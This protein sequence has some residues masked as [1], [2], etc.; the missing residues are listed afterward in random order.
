M[1]LH[2]QTA[3]LANEFLPD[4]ESD[5]DLEIAS[6]LPSKPVPAETVKSIGE[7]EAVTGTRPIASRFNDV[8]TEFLV[9]KPDRI[10]A[11]AFDPEDER[12]RLLDTQEYTA[13]TS[14]EVEEAL[15]DQLYE[16]REEHV[17]PYLVERDLLPKFKL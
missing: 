13:E 9:Y 16:W 3:I 7:S 6:V 8:V 14:H 17:V 15:M 11:L 12:W 1:I 5:D 4:M 2:C 10:Y